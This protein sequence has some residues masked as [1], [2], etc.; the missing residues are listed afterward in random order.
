MIMMMMIMMMIMMIMMMILTHFVKQSRLGI[1][2]EIDGH[3]R[4]A[5]AAK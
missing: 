5:C 4:E 3:G 1:I 2:L